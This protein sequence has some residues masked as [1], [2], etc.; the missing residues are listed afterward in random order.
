[1]NHT[2]RDNGQSTVGAILMVLVGLIAFVA[3]IVGIGYGIAA[4]NRG[5]GKEIRK[6][7]VQVEREVNQC[8]QQYTET[9]VRSMRDQIVQ[10]NTNAVELAPTRVYNPQLKII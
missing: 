4:Y 5:P 6:S 3:L 10:Y 7:E 2:T 9:Q 1:M 8:S